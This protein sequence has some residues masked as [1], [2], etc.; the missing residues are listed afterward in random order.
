MEKEDLTMAETENSSVPAPAPDDGG[1]S[2]KREREEEPLAAAEED[3]AEANGTGNHTDGG[4]SRKRARESETESNSSLGKSGGEVVLT[5]QEAAIYDRQIRVW[6]V[7]A[8]RRLSKARVLVVGVSGVIAE[9]CKNIVLAGIGSLTLLDD[10]PVTAEAAS[11]NFLIYP[12]DIGSE[13][14]STAT[15]CATS[16]REYN[17]MVNV[18]I[19][20]GNILDRPEE[21]FD[22]FDAVILDKA[23]LS[24]KKHVNAVCRSRPQ[25]VA[26]YAVDCRYS[27]GS[28]F[29]DLQTVTYTSKKKA[30]AE[31]T[32]DTKKFP[33]LEEALSVRLGS[34][35]RRTSNALFATRIIDEFEDREKRQ[36]G[37]ISS[38]DL[39]ILLEFAREYL[40][41]QGSSL[42]K[43]VEKLLQRIADAGLSELPPVSAIMGGILGQE[44]IKASSC[45]GEPLRNYFFFDTSDGKG[46]IEDIPP[47]SPPPV[48]EIVEP[49]PAPQTVDLD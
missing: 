21:F 38:E 15:V 10:R 30:A 27:C 14:N 17:P 45:K 26:F 29:V 2:R 32:E 1:E 7:E 6:G 41:S 28:L 20:K 24:V 47:Q 44:I 46:I 43:P 12:E 34:L 25:K 37:Q 3:G 42:S 48:K 40:K 31:A 23:S 8:Q 49:V 16:L 13:R 22:N 18:G 33:S 11:T 4:A 5:E 39:P 35:P 19:Q 36:P 9:T